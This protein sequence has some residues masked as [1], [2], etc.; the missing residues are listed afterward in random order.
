MICEVLCYV[1]LLIKKRSDFCVEAIRQRVA[2][3]L[4]RII[5][6]SKC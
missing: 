6:D 2:V 3:I 5:L 4:P 1:Q